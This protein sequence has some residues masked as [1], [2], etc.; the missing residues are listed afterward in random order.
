MRLCR[1]FISLKIYICMQ[2][3]LE[4]TYIR[5][6]RHH[7]CEEIKT[8][9]LSTRQKKKKAVTMMLRW[10]C[11]SNHWWRTNSFTQKPK[12]SK[13]KWKVKRSNATHKLTRKSVIQSVRIRHSGIVVTTVAVATV[14]GVSVVYFVHLFK[15]NEAELFVVHIN[16]HASHT[17]TDVDWCMGGVPCACMCV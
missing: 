1:E 7:H 8:S 10:V 15:I 13:I 3:K 12:K 16:L 11:I 5:C 6:S 2:M 14:A 4:N 9:L 17:M